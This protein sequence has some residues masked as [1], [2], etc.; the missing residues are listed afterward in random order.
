MNHVYFIT[1]PRHLKIGCS[2]MLQLAPSSG[3]LSSHP[4]TRPPSQT[5]QVATIVGYGTTIFL[6]P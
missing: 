1:G 6:H 5:R 3:T 4:P 2:N